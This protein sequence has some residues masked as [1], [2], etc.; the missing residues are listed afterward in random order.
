MW[1]FVAKMTPGLERELASTALMEWV[2][3][4]GGTEALLARVES[5]PDD[6]PGRFKLAAFRTAAGL[7]AHRDPELALAFI[8][9][10]AEGPY[11]RNLLK[12]FAVRRVKDDGP[13]TMQMLLDRPA[14]RERQRALR[15]TYR[16][17]LGFD[18][19]AA[20]A[21]MPETAAADPRFIPLCDIYAVALAQ[22]DREHRG[23]SM[24]RAAQWSEGIADS[25]TQHKTRVELGVIWLSYE[26]EAASAWLE[27]RGIEAEVRRVSALRRQFYGLP[28][29]GGARPE[30]PE[31]SGNPLPTGRPAGS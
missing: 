15:E 11:S 6:A 27:E 20:L 29:A 26:P 10:H 16:R 31:R 23:Q 17:W 30:G 5:L 19:Q 13:G 1:D 28:R 18:R 4:R 3:T 9:R 25:A 8:D 21:W 7:A 22:S 14:G 2:V 12:R 24:A